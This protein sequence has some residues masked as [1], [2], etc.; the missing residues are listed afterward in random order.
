L[1]LENPLNIRAK[2]NTEVISCARSSIFL[3]PPGDE[4]GQ[5]MADAMETLI[6]DQNIERYALLLQ[7]EKHPDKR[8][9]L[10]QLLAKEAAR[11]PDPG[12]RAA[13]LRKLRISLT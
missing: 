9:I 12:R 13:I 6:A 4:K 7:E 5:A 3:A 2:I 1:A 10:S 8:R 11:H